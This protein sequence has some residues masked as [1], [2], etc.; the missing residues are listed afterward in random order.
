MQ[1]FAAYTGVCIDHSVCSVCVGYQRVQLWTDERKSWNLKADTWATCAA[2][3]AAGNLR[4]KNASNRCARE[5]ATKATDPL[6]VATFFFVAPKRLQ[7][8][9]ENGVDSPWVWGQRGVVRGRWGLLLFQFQGSLCTTAA[10]HH[11]RSIKLT[12]KLFTCQLCAKK[13]CQQRQS[14]K[15]E[16]SETKLEIN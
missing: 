6:R 8:Y 10:F 15:L 7:L 14:A 9:G 5:A 13:Q 11:W 2:L 16:R 4:L 3:G 12:L 1:R